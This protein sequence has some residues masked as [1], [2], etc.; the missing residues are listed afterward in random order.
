MKWTTS[1]FQSEYIKVTWQKRSS[2]GSGLDLSNIPTI[3]GK[4]Q[5]SMSWTDV[6]GRRNH[7]RMFTKHLPMLSKNFSTENISSFGVFRVQPPVATEKSRSNCNSYNRYNYLGGLYKWSAFWDASFPGMSRVF[8]LEVMHK[9][10][11]WTSC[12]YNITNLFFPN[13]IYDKKH[14]IFDLFRALTKNSPDLN[15]GP[16]DLQSDALPTELSRQLMEWMV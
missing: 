14:K 3:K 2:A 15:Q 12:L 7:A 9:W 11:L 6:L 5:E 10:R 13:A 4:L 16:S 1:H 8:S